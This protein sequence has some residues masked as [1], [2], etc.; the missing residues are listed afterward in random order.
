MT[1]YHAR[2]YIPPQV[3][4][5][6]TVAEQFA[7]TRSSLPE[8]GR[9][10]AVLTAALPHSRI[11][12]IGTG[13]GVGTA[14]MASAL[15]PDATLVTIDTNAD[16]VTAVRQIFADD[17][18]IHI[19][20][21][22]WRELRAYAPFQLLFADGGRAKVE[23]PDVVLD[24]VAPGGVVVLDDLTPEEYWPASWKGQVDLTRQFWLNT[25]RVVATEIR[26]TERHA[27][28]VATRIE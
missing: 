15:H 27:V 16:Y 4:H 3:H 7:F 28:I 6:Q 17:P 1:T 12:E 24:L 25:A 20:H 22:D 14:W 11:G 23:Y 8:V 9:L 5:A 2:S 21:G 18:R 10:L 13:C 19:L 26:V